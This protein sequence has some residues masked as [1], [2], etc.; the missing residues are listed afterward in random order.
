MRLRCSLTVSVLL[1]ALSRPVYAD[2]SGNE[3]KAK[4][5]SNDYFLS[6][7]CVGYIVGAISTDNASRA[8]FNSALPPKNR[9]PNPIVCPP[10]GVTNGQSKDIVLKF[11]RDNPARLHE[12]AAFNVLQAMAEAF[13]CPSSAPRA[14]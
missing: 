14:P 13:P 5:E 9:V 2:L 11:F 4:C 1:V 7:M 6:G 10:P 8:M 12:P 3:L